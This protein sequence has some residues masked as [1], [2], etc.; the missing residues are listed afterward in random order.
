MK[1]YEKPSVLVREPDWETAFLT[2]SNED[3]PV[4]HFDPEFDD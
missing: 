1:P 3:Y 2:G 4:D